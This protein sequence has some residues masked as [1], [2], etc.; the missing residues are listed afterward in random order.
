VT[1]TIAKRQQTDHLLNRILDE[2]DLP[3]I[4]KRLDPGLLTRLI[5]HVGLEDSGPIVFNATA[6]QLKNVFDEDL[7]H[8][9]GPGRAEGFNPRRFGLWLRIL[10][11]NGP[12]SAAQTVLELDE[13]LLI[14]GICRIVQVA[15]L[16]DG[17]KMDYDGLPDHLSNE[18]LSQVLAG[19]RLVSKDDAS[20]DAI[21][22]LL[23]QL[24]ETDG[25]TLE[26]LLYRCC[27]FSEEYDDDNGGL[28]RRI[29]AI[30]MLE[31]D[32]AAEREKRKEAKGFVTPVSA[33]FFLDQSRREHLKRIV[34]ERRIPHAA[35]LY[36]KSAESAHNASGPLQS[37]GNETAGPVRKGVPS[38]IETLRN[39]DLPPG[40]KRQRLSYDGADFGEAHFPLTDAIRAAGESNP[41]LYAR[42]ILELTFLSNT[43]ISGCEFRG[44]AF[45]PKEAA[46]AALSVCNLGSE[47]LLQ[48]GNT[49]DRN[50][51]ESET[52]SALLETDD[53]VRLFRV[54]WKIL[55]DRI[56]LVTAKR[57]LAFMDGINDKISDPDEKREAARMA[58]R[59][60]AGISSGR[61]WEI[62]GEMDYLQLFLDGET[63]EALKELIQEYPTFTKS[64]CRRGGIRVAP[65]IGSFEH[66][67]TLRYFLENLAI[68]KE[69]P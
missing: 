45:H 35:R 24:N 46:E 51:P 54:G 48:T 38:F 50:R 60:R 1:R 18:S 20:W 23:V 58:R 27:R 40:P 29:S 52:V 8:K 47:Y 61:P 34:S 10:M 65:H 57:L 69:R 2:P 62:R 32:V 12:H 25:E 41:D 66:I 33:A 14:L 63:T 15:S 42:R 6:A 19:Y 30:Q 43:L 4:I 49:R 13:D 53:L 21:L 17:L 55:F 16:N 9:K 31:E 7:W 26:R 5:R 39:A 67:R 68:E 22:G 64:I 3:A 56:I 11:E 44:R 37:S 28:I 36:M 59:L